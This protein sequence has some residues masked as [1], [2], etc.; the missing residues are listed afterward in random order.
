MFEY[1]SFMAKKPQGKFKMDKIPRK[2]SKFKR[3]KIHKLQYIKF[4]NI[5]YQVDC[6]QRIKRHIPEQVI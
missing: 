2:N 4:K 5:K 6:F 3:A 1:F